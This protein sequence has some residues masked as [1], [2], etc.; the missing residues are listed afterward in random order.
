[1][2]QLREYQ[3]EIIERILSSPYDRIMVQSPTGSGKTVIACELIQKYLNDSKTVYFIAHRKELIDQT[4]D[5][6]V[7]H[8]GI[9]P[10]VIM[11]K[12][13]RSAPQKTIQLASIQTLSCNDDIKEIIDVIIIDEAH[14]SC[15]NSYV[16]FIKQHPQAKIIG[17]TATPDRL[18]KKPLDSIFQ[19]LYQTKTIREL[20]TLGHLVQPRMFVLPA[21]VGLDAIDEFDMEGSE[22]AYMDPQVIGNYVE[23][24]DM[25]CSDRKTILFTQSI[26]HSIE[27]CSRIFHKTKKVIK[28]LDAQTSKSKRDKIISDLRNNIIHG[29]SNV[30]VLTE[31]FDDPQIS[32]VMI[33]KNTKSLVNYLQ[34][35]GRALRPYKNKTDCIIL[36]CNGSF[37]RHGAIE[38]D[39]FWSLT[40]PPKKEVGEPILHINGNKGDIE[41][42]DIILDLVEHIE[43]IKPFGRLSGRDYFN[44]ID[45]CKTYEELLQKE[46]QYNYKPGWAWINMKKRSQA[47]IRK[48]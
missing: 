40:P 7:T 37:E 27:L 32:A 35:A 19:I 48:V 11:A 17:F 15:A 22:R 31:G 1:M 44:M 5:H 12:D 25:R 8:L 47:N 34:M 20:I 18:D 39:R 9:T 45:S 16:K 41:K 46:I 29:I 4:Y 2:I 14:H 10:G 13:N 36:D 3:K 6:L 23:E 26:V 24:Y 38:K 21:P 28:H 42:E 43:E 30:G 33:C